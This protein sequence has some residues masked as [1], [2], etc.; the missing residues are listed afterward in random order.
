MDIIWV[1]KLG[2]QHPLQYPQ[3]IKY[4]GV[5]V[6]KQ[7]KALYDNNFK[8]MK[9]EI[10]KDIRRWKDIPCSWISRNNIVKLDILPKAIYRF[11]AIPI[12][13]LA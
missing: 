2:K 11:N 1:N 6:I 13:I 9:K 8:S 7:V 4:L 5:M 12:K 3:I 10:E